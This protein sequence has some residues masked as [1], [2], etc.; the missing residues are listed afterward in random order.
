MKKQNSRATLLVEYIDLINEQGPSSKEAHDFRRRH[1][2]DSELQE[3]ITVVHKLRSS[4]V[5]SGRGGAHEQ[6]LNTVVHK[7]RRIF[8]Q[9]DGVDC[10][11]TNPSA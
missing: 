4:G 7:L 3:L 8:Y 9:N 6:E 11:V 2:K 10:I 1:A 5:R